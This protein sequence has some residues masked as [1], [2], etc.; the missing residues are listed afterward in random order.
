YC[1]VRVSARC[2]RFFATVLMRRMGL[3]VRLVSLSD[4]Q[5]H[6]WTCRPPG[7]REFAP[8]PQQGL[9]LQLNDEKAPSR[10][11]EPFA[12]DIRGGII[13]RSVRAARGGRVG[14]PPGASRGRYTEMAGPGEAP[15]RRP[16]GEEP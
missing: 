13:R 7:H 8:R 2:L 3:S 14:G 12:R 15:T 10:T 9:V 6:N 4:A 1:V 11:Q 16:C 5:N